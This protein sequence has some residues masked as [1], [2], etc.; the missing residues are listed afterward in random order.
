MAR[1]RP[2]QAPQLLLWS[3]CDRRKGANTGTEP[4]LTNSRCAGWYHNP[5]CLWQGVAVQDGVTTTVACWNRCCF[6]ELLLE[7][8]VSFWEN[9]LQEFGVLLIDSPCLENLSDMFSC[10][11]S[12]SRCLSI[13]GICYVFG[14]SLSQKDSIEKVLQEEFLKERPLLR[15]TRNQGHWTIR[16]EAQDVCR[17]ISSVQWEL[18]R[19]FK[20]SLSIRF[21]CC[22]KDH[23]T[24]AQGRLPDRML[25]VSFT[26]FCAHSM[27]AWQRAKLEASTTGVASRLRRLV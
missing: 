14:G 8:T 2:P 6:E 15:K 18:I 24:R 21:P 1:P 19:T 23:C 17:A 11:L 13:P 12:F 9:P 26:S 22:Y 7:E 27:L 4:A 16:T 20:S 10:H 25:L 3:C 5:S